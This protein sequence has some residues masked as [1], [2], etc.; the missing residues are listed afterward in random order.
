MLNGGELH[1]SRATKPSEFG[2]SDCAV[3]RNSN[4]CSRRHQLSGSDRCF[5]VVPVRV[6]F[7]F[8]GSVIYA[9]KTRGALIVRH[10]GISSPSDTA[11]N[12]GGVESSITPL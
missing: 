10:G 12:P 5:A 3:L 1:K 7:M 6:A 2:H 9:P 11:S 4:E 8:D